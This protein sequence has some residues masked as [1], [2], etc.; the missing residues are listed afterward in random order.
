MAGVGDGIIL[1][2]GAAGITAGTV[3][4]DGEITDAITAV[5]PDV[6]RV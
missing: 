3:T 2:T 4:M 1:T 6:V 5:T